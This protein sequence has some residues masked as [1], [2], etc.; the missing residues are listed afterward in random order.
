MKS[1]TRVQFPAES[2]RLEFTKK[3]EEYDQSLANEEVPEKRKQ[4]ISDIIRLEKNLIALND[5]TAKK[6]GYL[7][8]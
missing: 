8:N 6:T 7:L 5:I 3:L 4:I 1:F 2:L